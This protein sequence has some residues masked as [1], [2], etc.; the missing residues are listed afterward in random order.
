MILTRLRSWDLRTTCSND[1]W[2]PC[3]TCTSVSPA[4]QT[5]EQVE[6]GWLL[7]MLSWVT[8]TMP[9]SRQLKCSALTRPLQSAGQTFSLPSSGL[10]MPGISMTACR[11]LDC[12]LGN[13]P[14]CAGRHFPS[15]TVSALRW[16]RLPPCSLNYG[17]HVTLRATAYKPVD[18]AGKPRT[19]SL[20]AQAQY[21]S[22]AATKQPDGQIILI[23]RNLVK[24][25]NKKYFCFSET[26]S[27]VW[28]ARLTRREGRSRSS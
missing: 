26:Q 1:T 21:R 2:K 19:A 6:C 27:G 23:F 4:R 12:Q 9:G 17:G 11:R 18:H 16:L 22:V 3:R 28:S 25:Q 5:C 8:S 24:S 15:T 20:P 7:P 14:R 13:G 10:K